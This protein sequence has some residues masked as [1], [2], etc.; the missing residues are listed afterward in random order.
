MMKR[1]LLIFFCLMVLAA[2]SS[3]QSA[4]ESEEPA[5]TAVE[6]TEEVAEATAVPTE[7]PDPTEAPTTEP[8]PTAVPEPTEEPTAE[9][10]IV[11]PTENLTEGCVEEYAEGVDYFPQ[12]AEVTYSSGFSID[13]F[14]NYKV[15]TVH[16]P[17]PGAEEVATYVLVQCGTAVPDGFEEAVVIETPIDS[18]AAMSTTYLPHL[19]TLNAI[20]KLIGLDS[21]AFASTAEV[22]ERIDAGA[23]TEIGF[24]A[25]VNIEQVLDLN[26]DLVMTYSSGSADFDAQP[27]LEEAGITV[28]VNSD[29]LDQTPL[30]QAEWAK[31]LATFFNQEAAANDWFAE[32]TSEYNQMVELAATAESQPTVFLGTPYEGTWY[33]AGGQ[34]YVAQLLEDAGA[35]YVWAEDESE[36]TL[37]LDF[38]TVYDEAQAAEYWINLG[39][40]FSLEDL[41]ATDERFAD[42]AAYQAGNLFNNDALTTELGGNDYYEGGAANPHLVLADL[43][44]IFHPELLPDHELV[45]YRVVE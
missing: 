31:F 7:A 33:M 39:F 5:P 27:K 12:K 36:T 28:V 22:R 2:C 44:K 21:L 15:V 24:G 42:F 45:Y 34:S 38:E 19:P 30:G 26:P 41:I 17:Y 1:L 29:Y 11:A 43:I 23:I 20:D 32:V 6:T 13:Y 10:E 8:E 40:V 25:E 4:P 3:S 37:F 9:P 35:S 18:F 14:D 16:S